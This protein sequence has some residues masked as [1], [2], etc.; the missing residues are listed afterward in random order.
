MPRVYMNMAEKAAAAEKR[1]QEKENFMLR[2]I[3]KDTI[4]RKIGYDYICQ[5]TGLSQ[6]TVSKVVNR[7]EDCTVEQIRLVCAAA[8][9]PLIITIAENCS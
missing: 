3:M 1:R 5:K 4:C 9:I 2:A 7:P 6:P 8:K